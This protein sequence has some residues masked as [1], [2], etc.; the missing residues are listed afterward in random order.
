MLAH[1]FIIAVNTIAA[2]N[3]MKIGVTLRTKEVVSLLRQN[4]PGKA[5]LI[6]WFVVYYSL[7]CIIGS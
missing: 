3:K 5:F 7:V 2:S 6:P 1:A 4:L